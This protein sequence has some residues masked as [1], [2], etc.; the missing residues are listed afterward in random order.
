MSIRYKLFLGF[1]IVLVLAAGVALYGIRAITDAGNQ[2]VQLY[3]HAF[4]ATS[5]ARA[6]QVRFNEARAAIE[7]G[8]MS[9]EAAPKAN[10][11]A[12]NAAMKDVIEELK[13]VGDRLGKAQSHDSL[14][15]AQ[16]LGQDWSQ[17]ALVA[18]KGKAKGAA[19]A[20]VLTPLMDKAD[21]VAEVLDQ[22]VEDASAYGFE[23]RSAAEAS[24][25]ASRRNLIILAGATGVI[26]VVL[27]L[28]IAY[29]FT[30]PLRRAM[31]FSERIA[32][33]DLS[34]EMMSKRRDEFGRLLVSLGQMQNALRDQ[35]DKEHAVADAK[36]REHAA[37]VVRR[38]QMEEQIAQ[39]RDGVGTMLETMGERMNVTAQSLSSIASEAD[40]KANEAA[41]AARATSDNVATVAAAAEELGASVQNI[42]TQLQ[43]AKSVVE[44]ATGEAAIA[45]DTVLGLA[46]SAKRIDAVVSLIRAIAEQTNLLAL[47]ATIE[48][49]RAGEAGRGFAVVASEVKAL[50]NQTAKATEEISAQISTVQ[51][52]TNSAVDKIGAISS[53]MAEIKE[54]TGAIAAAIHEQGAATGEI[55]RNIQYAAAATQNVATNV[56]GTTKAIGETNTAAMEV[57]EAAD[58]FSSRSNALRGSVDEFLSSVAAA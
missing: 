11:D 28:G 57:I 35:R 7:R 55:A 47:N 41:E 48:A 38:Q 5:S 2:V 42:A 33:G 14:R 18:I 40:G 19:E 1:S 3:D 23:F 27:S 43:Q 46:E 10:I 22:V 24:V 44:H 52:S 45:N 36:E 25:V 54:L 51:A 50:A 58:Y 30:R 9:P 29:S 26:A 12:F 17:V 15:K 53:V 31:E 20:A 16:S 8:L 13:V 6:A 39:F 56:A 34:Q 37:Q 49:A 4:M 21:A 32:A